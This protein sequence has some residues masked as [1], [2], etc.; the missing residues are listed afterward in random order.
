MDRAGAGGEVVRV[1]LAWPH[2]AGRWRRAAIAATTR[3][4]GSTDVGHWTSQFSSF[5][6]V[7]DRLTTRFQ[8]NQTAK[9]L[10][11][12]ADNLNGT[13]RPMYHLRFLLKNHV[14]IHNHY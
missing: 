3:R 12:R 1:G 5:G 7:T 10:L 13:C 9:R 4:A 8:H 14:I 6:A 11:Y 2:G